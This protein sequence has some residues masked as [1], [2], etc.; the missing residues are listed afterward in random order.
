MVTTT[1]VSRKRC[2]L[3]LT[4]TEISQVIAGRVTT[5]TFDNHSPDSC[6]QATF[7]RIK[8]LEELHVRDSQQIESQTQTINDMS[9]WLGICNALIDAGRNW[10]EYR[11]KRQSD[12]A[13]LRN[14]FGTGD[15]E[16][17]HPLWRAEEETAKAMEAAIAVL[18]KRNAS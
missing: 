10:L 17:S 1:P 9:R 3:C 15:R 4:I 2:P 12:I 13:R 6:Q 18:D 16:A 8:V 14:A 5:V 11:A 7:Q